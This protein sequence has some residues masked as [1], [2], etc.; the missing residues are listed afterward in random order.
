MDNPLLIRAFRDSIVGFTKGVAC[1]AQIEGMH[2]ENQQRILMGQSIA[3]PEDAFQVVSD[4]L[5]KIGFQLQD[6]VI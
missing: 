2:A 6:I 3:Y 1:L 4:T 5:S